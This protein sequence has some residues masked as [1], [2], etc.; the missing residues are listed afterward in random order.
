MK[1]SMFATTTAQIGFTE[2]GAPK[3]LNDELPAFSSPRYSQR[4]LT[5]RVVV[6]S[7]LC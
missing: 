3:A 6:R 4:L 2:A 5:V 1:A 7:K